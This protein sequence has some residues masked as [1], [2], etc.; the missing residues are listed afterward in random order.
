MS[1]EIAIRVQNLSKC[2]HIYDNPLD[3]LKQLVIPKL[4]R[5]IPALNKLFPTTDSLIP[6]S[7]GAPILHGVSTIH[8]PPCH[9][10]PIA[11]TLLDETKLATYTSE[12]DYLP[13]NLY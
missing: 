13:E 5:A 12:R 7:Q 11:P 8:F 3:R 1:S 10:S 6:A 2:Y 9:G 4:C